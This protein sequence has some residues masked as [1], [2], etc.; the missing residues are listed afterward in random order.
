MLIRLVYDRQNRH[1][2]MDI[3]NPPATKLRSF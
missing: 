1:V 3:D 2:E